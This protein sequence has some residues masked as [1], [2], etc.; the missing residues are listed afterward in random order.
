MET[1]LRA[2]SGLASTPG[3]FSSPHGGEE[4][5]GGVASPQ[6]PAPYPL[7]TATRRR[8]EE[9]GAALATMLLLGWQCDYG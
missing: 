1:S 8:G 5:G 2:G 9:C 3:P 6:P 4:K 7:R